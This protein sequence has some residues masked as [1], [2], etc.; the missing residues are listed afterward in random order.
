MKRSLIIGIICIFIL[1]AECISVLA[2]IQKTE[3]ITA[4]KSDQVQRIL[5]IGTIKN[6]NDSGFN[7]IS[8]YGKVGFYI[9][10]GWKGGYMGKIR[11]SHFTIYEDL[12]HGF[13]SEHFI[14][15]FGIQQSGPY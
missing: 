13:V 9:S 8:F 11:D 1:I 14:I 15:G 5:I 6:Y 12:F 10:I 3:P 7:L 4:K 2:L